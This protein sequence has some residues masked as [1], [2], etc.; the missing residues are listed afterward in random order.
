MALITKV[1]GKIIK[2]S[3]GYVLEKQV[4]TTEN[5]FKK[6]KVLVDKKKNLPNFLFL[7]LNRL[8]YDIERVIAEGFINNELEIYSSSFLYYLEQNLDANRFFDTRLEPLKKYPEDQKNPFSNLIR[9][10]VNSY[11]GKQFFDH[12]KKY[13]LRNKELNKEKNKISPTRKFLDKEKFKHIFLMQKDPIVERLVF[14]LKIDLSKENF[15]NKY[16][17]DLIC[18]TLKKD[19]KFLIL[20]LEDKKT[21]IKKRFYFRLEHLKS[22]KKALKETKDG[23]EGIYIQKF[24]D[25]NIINLKINLLR[26]EF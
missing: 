23:I 4:Q 5:P 13:T 15:P 19:S 17:K 1:S 26:E 2:V 20:E 3:D 14:N 12:I 21:E 8:K 11:E 22:K 10:F 7:N 18:I 6:Q 16:E 24:M 9:I 25:K